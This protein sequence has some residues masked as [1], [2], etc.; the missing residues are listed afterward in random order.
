MGLIGLMMVV[1]LWWSVSENQHGGSR[2]HIFSR[3]MYEPQFPMM[4]QLDQVDLDRFSKTYNQADPIKFIMGR[5][6]RF[7]HTKESTWVY[8]TTFPQESDQPCLQKA[9]NRCQEPI[10]L[11][12][13]QEEKLAGLAVQTPKDIVRVSP[14]FN[15]VYQQC[16]D[17]IK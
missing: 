17:H 13:K 2:D 8:P 11:V 9:M 1:S 7:Y 6:Y 16:V 14:C 5:P 3:F 15:R 12:K 10:V 4:S